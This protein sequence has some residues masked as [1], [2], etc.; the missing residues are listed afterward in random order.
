M[1]PLFTPLKLPQDYSSERERNSSR[2][3]NLT[4]DSAD[5]ESSK[6]FRLARNALEWCILESGA[7]FKLDDKNGNSVRCYFLS[8]ISFMNGVS[9]PYRT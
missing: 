8:P 7:R 5:R 2:Y 4:E 6:M 9:Q 1:T 3:D